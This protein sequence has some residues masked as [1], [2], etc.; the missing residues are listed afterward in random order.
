MSDTLIKISNKFSSQSRFY[1]PPGEGVRSEARQHCGGGPGLGP[2]VHAAHPA[3]HGQPGPGTRHQQ[4]RKQVVNNLPQRNIKYV[5]FFV[6]AFF[7]RIFMKYKTSS[8]K[9][10]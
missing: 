3:Q 8:S 6:T 4:L 7:I 10:L 2:A 9:F 5:I 1:L